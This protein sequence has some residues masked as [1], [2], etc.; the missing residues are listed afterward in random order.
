VPFGVPFR[1]DE[2]CLHLLA[3]PRHGGTHRVGVSPRSPQTST[4]PIDPDTQQPVRR[5]QI[6]C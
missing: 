2:S 1:K 6:P 5:L 3:P 4:L